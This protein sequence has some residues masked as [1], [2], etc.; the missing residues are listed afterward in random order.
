ME[1]EHRTYIMKKLLSS[2]NVGYEDLL[3]YKKT[4][5]VYTQVIAIHFGEDRE[6]RSQRDRNMLNILASL[7]AVGPGINPAAVLDKGQ[8]ITHCSLRVDGHVGTMA[9]NAQMWCMA[10]AESI[11]LAEMAKL[12]GHDIS[13][14]NL[15]GTIESKCRHKGVAGFLCIGLLAGLGV[16]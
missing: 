1:G 14:M 12:L 7:P 3:L 11:T 8:G 9:T 4:K 13:T 5:L 6:P 15:A 10:D 2:A 16:G